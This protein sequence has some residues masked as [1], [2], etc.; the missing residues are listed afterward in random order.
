ME[1]NEK[2]VHSVMESDVFPILLDILSE[3]IILDVKP[4]FLKDRQNGKELPFSPELMAQAFT[5]GL[6]QVAK[7]WVQNKNTVKKKIWCARRLLCWKKCT[8]FRLLAP[9]DHLPE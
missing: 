9:Q 1:A 8:D 7:W 4:H 5:G 2:L 6:L 3:Q